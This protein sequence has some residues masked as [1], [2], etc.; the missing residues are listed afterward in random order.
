MIMERLNLILT[1]VAIAL[2]IFGLYFANEL[3]KPNPELSMS[4]PWI[5]VYDQEIDIYLS[6]DRDGIALVDHIEFEVNNFEIIDECNREKFNLSRPYEFWTD[7][8]IIQP[9]SKIYS[10][11][12]LLDLET[13]KYF[14]LKEGLK[15]GNGDVDQI[16]LLYDIQNRTMEEKG[17][18]FDSKI[19]VHWCNLSQCGETKILESDSFRV[20]RLGFCE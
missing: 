9:E 16:T 3:S 7:R 4:E 11:N 13:D 14:Q 20:E 5:Q 10:I 15:Y 2:A 19:R 8:I 18:S 12:Q 17:Y 1:L 6:N